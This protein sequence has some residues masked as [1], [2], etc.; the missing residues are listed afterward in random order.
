MWKAIVAISLGSAVGALLRWVLGLKLNHLLP[1]I[2]PGTLAPKA[3]Q[4][5]RRSL[6]KLLPHSEIVVR[7][8]LCACGATHRVPKGSRIPPKTKVL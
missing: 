1:A 5:S 4:R 6:R 3:S 7:T 8:I 2:P